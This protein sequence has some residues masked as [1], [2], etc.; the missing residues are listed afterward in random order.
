MK[1]LTFGQGPGV[2]VK[3]DDPYVSNR[4]CR[5]FERDGRYYVEDL[6]STNSTWILPSG[7]QVRGPRLLLPGDRVRIGRTT[8]PWSVDDDYHVSGFSDFA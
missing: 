8:L 7:V 3:I 5:I 2:D 1:S 4:H 6:G